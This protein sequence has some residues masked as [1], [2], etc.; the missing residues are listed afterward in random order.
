MAWVLSAFDKARLE[1]QF[2]MQGKPKSGNRE[3]QI[4]E[5]KLIKVIR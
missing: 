4:D 2:A 1:T 5:S 3:K